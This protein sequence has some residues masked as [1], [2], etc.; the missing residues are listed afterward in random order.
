[1]QLRLVSVDSEPHFR[2]LYEPAGM[3]FSRI[4]AFYLVSPVEKWGA[5]RGK[6]GV[7][8]RAQTLN[9]YPKP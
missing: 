7:V 2:P 3:L 6:F 8:E 9:P 5:E 4:K 1:M